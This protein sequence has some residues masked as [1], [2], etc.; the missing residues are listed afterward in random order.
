MK[1]YYKNSFTQFSGLRIL[2]CLICLYTLTAG[3]AAQSVFTAARDTQER[4]SRIEAAPLTPTAIPLTGNVTCATL[5]TNSGNEPLFNH[6]TSNNEFKLN[7]RPPLGNS[8]PY[9][10]EDGASP[11]REVVS[12]PDYPGDSVSL[13]NVR[14]VPSGADI[15]TFDFTSTKLIT[16]VIVKSA[17]QANVYPYPSGTLGGNPDGIGLTTATGQEI[18]HISFCYNPSATVKIVKQVEAFGGGTSSPQSFQFTATNLG[19]SPFS[20][21]DDDAGPGNDTFTNNNITA[22]GPG[23][24]ITVTEAAMGGSGWMLFAINCSGA[25]NQTTNTNVPNRTATIV[26]N[27]GASVTCT[28]VNRQETLTAANAQIGGRVLTE[29]GRPIRGAL[30]TVFN[31][32][33]LETQT[34]R[35]G[36]MGYYLFRD[37]PVGNFY[38]VTVGHARYNFP[39]NSQA[40]T[41]NDDLGEVNFVAGF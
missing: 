9:T 36:S 2:L 18:S 27:E 23:N 4:N 40:F 7:F 13:Q 22:F 8:G 41:L 11:E 20:L 35:T 38:I 28:F 21:I 30:V 34:L 25:G 31:A 26:V 37:L 29:A 19:A 5:N 12:G 32:S 1:M 17:N 33:T 14:R 3:A 15:N 16:A 24:T 10:F 39:N 6:I